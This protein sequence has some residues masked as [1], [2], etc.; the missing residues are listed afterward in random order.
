ML[1][2]QTFGTGG[3]IE[4]TA[5]VYAY[6]FLVPYNAT[7]GNDQRIYFSFSFC[8]CVLTLRRY[9]TG[10][11]VSRY[12]ITEAYRHRKKRNGEERRGK[13]VDDVYKRNRERSRV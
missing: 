1:K 2:N 3:G 6:S 5:Y 13:N 8:H 12:S 11:L 9:V 10:C 7:V 4:V